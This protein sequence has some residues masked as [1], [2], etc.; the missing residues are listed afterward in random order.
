[1]QYIVTQTDAKEVRDLI[2][3]FNNIDANSDGFIT[4]DEFCV[5]LKS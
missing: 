4:N 1:M 2:E 3:V 5:A